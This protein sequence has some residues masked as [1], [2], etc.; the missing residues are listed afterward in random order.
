MRARTD[1][2]RSERRARSLLAGGPGTGPRFPRCRVRGDKGAVAEGAQL[3]LVARD[4][5]RSPQWAEALRVAGGPDHS[6]PGGGG[7]RAQGDRRPHRRDVDQHD[8]S[9]VA[10]AGR[11]RDARRY[12]DSPFRHA[13]H[14]GAKGLRI[15]G[16]PRKAPAGSG[17]GDARGRA[18]ERHRDSR[19]VAGSLRHLRGREPLHASRKWCATTRRH[20]I[21][22]G[23]SGKRVPAL[24]R[25]IR[26]VRRLRAQAERWTEHQQQT[27]SVRICVHA[28]ARMRAL[29]HQWS[30]RGRCHR[31]AALS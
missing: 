22:P 12:T 21:G 18:V 8:R 20:E 30:S 16:Q 1:L 26:G 29:C 9:R 10:G 31:K 28:G 11:H 4:R 23:L 24:R 14:H 25:R 19:P 13:D 17:H 2:R 27:Q 5:R 7:T 3:A 6:A 15:P